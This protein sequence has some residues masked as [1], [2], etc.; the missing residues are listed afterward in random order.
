MHV[1][2]NFLKLVDF[3]SYIAAT[4]LESIYLTKVGTTVY[5]QLQ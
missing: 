4:Y 5:D 2:V 3:N 1:E